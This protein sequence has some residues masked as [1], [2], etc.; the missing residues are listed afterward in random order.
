MITDYCLLKKRL[1]TKSAED[2]EKGHIVRKFMK[3]NKKVINRLAF[4]F[5]VIVSGLTIACEPEQIVTVI[6]EPNVTE[7]TIKIELDVPD[8]NVVVPVVK[9]DIPDIKVTISDVEIP[10]VKSKP[11]TSQ[12]EVAGNV[13]IKYAGFFISGTV[14]AA[15][16]NI[17]YKEFSRYR[18]AKEVVE[19]HL[20]P[21]L[22]AADQ[23]LGQIVSLSRKDFKSIYI[24]N[25]DTERERMFVLYLFAQFWAQVE[26]LR[27]ESLHVSLN[28][29]KNGKLLLQF[30]RTLRAGKNR[31]TSRAKQQAIGESVLFLCRA[32]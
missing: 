27:K 24:D 15:L 29:H 21:I 2:T 26:I 31:I 9:V 6:V 30:I 8:I 5:L 1:D 23:L 7:Q 17:L 14:I 16:I 19:R 25:Q 11:D 3:D 32:C 28:K 12:V 20:D 18:R 10:P 4:S 22:K 13:W